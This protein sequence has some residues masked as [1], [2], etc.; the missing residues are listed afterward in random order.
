MKGE[1]EDN[2]QLVDIPFNPTD[3]AEQFYLGH[4]LYP[5]RHLDED[6]RSRSE[7][8]FVESM[9][10]RPERARVDCG[11]ATG[12]MINQVFAR[13]DHEIKSG[14]ISLSLSN[15]YK[16][17]SIPYSSFKLQILFCFFFSLLKASSNGLK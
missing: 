13:F 4:A 10:L 11:L 1:R 12:E 14:F 2:E 17:I 15:I 9:L 6:S 3:W 7:A 16:Y 5:M 8:A